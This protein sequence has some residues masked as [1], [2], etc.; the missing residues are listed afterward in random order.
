[1]AHFGNE[2]NV[3][4]FIPPGQATTPTIHCNTENDS[5]G[6]DMYKAITSKNWQM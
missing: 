2:T 6:D 3:F 1:M 4:A 5:L